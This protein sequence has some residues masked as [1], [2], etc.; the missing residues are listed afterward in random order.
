MKTHQ[1]SPPRGLT[2]VATGSQP[3]SEAEPIPAAL[4][5]G[6]W[7]QSCTIRGALARAEYLRG[8]DNQHAQQVA[9][10]EELQRLATE[11]FNL[12]DALENE[13]A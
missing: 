13:G 5:R 10:A 9:L 7:Q 11:A 8:T 12:A 3:A 4:R 1:S 6:L 2:S